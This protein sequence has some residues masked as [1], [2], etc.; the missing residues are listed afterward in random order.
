[1]C[2]QLKLTLLLTKMSKKSERA[3]EIRKIRIA[4]GQCP[5]CG[6]IN[7]RESYYCTE[8]LNKHNEYVK[9]TRA[10]YREM[11]M[12]SECG[13]NKVF[14]SEKTCIDCQ[15]KQQERRIK[16]HQSEEQRIKDNQCRSKGAKMRYRERLETGICT[17]CG[18]RKAA[19]GKKKCQICLDKDALIHRQRYFDKPNERERRIE[20]RLCY[21]CGQPLTTETGKSCKACQKK[22][23]DMALQR[24]HD[25]PYWRHDNKLLGVKL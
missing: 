11:G 24:E 10:F 13:K 19:Q 23:N 17:R 8:C 2:A 5:K 16:R 1:L 12:C 20:N 9:E 21:H 7:D 25:N 14:G 3:K 15:I 22:F 18:K 6:K 4:N